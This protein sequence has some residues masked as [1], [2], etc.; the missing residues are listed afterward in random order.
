MTRSFA[1]HSKERPQS[2]FRLKKKE[3]YNMVVITGPLNL[4]IAV[5]ATALDCIA[6][7]A[8]FRFC[9][10]IGWDDV[11]KKNANM[12]YQKT[13]RNW[14]MAQVEARNIGNEQT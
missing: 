4:S 8:D 10:I 7:G 14:R 1:R 11:A 6:S 3:F 2:C 13:A 12:E 5:Y 9:P